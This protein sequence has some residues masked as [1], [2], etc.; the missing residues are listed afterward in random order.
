MKCM[1]TGSIGGGIAMIEEVQESRNTERRLLVDQPFRRPTVEGIP[2]RLEDTFREV[3]RGID[4]Q[5]ELC[6]VTISITDR[7]GV[8]SGI[9]RRRRC[10]EAQGA[11]LAAVE[12]GEE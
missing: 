10:E 11:D 2:R 7:F 4:I 9:G 1:Q 5:E 12:A 6:Q 8:L 3:A